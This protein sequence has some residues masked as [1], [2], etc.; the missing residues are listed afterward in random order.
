M[1]AHP[2]PALM[3]MALVSLVF[4]GCGEGDGSEGGQSDQERLYEYALNTA[5]CMRGHGIDMPDPRPGRG[6]DITGDVNPERFELARRACREE[7][8]EPPV[9]ELSNEQRDEFRQAA[10]KYARCMRAHGIDIPDPTYDTNGELQITMATGV[11]D[12]APAFT[13]A[14]AKCRKYQIDRPTLKD[15]L[16]DGRAPNMKGKG[17]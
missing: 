10:L 16:P 17:G 11:D 7:L 14:N 6:L 9:P 2:N 5:E 4:A 15:P 3:A 13:A 12:D 8:G 1:A